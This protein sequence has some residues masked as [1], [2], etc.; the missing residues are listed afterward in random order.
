[1]P[2]EV[3]L[4]VPMPDEAIALAALRALRPEVERPA[5]DRFEAEVWLEGEILCLRIRARDTSS[6]RAA[7]N[8]F[9][10]WL[11]A[12]RDACLAASGA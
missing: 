1:M 7:L 8:S 9:L 12:L 10:S 3:V 4:R 2:H 5:S 11:G 6:L